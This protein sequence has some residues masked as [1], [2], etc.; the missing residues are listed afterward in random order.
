M[1]IETTSGIPFEIAAGD[2]LNFTVGFSGYPATSYG[3]TFILFNAGAVVATLTGTPSGS[4]FNVTASDEDTANYPPGR[5]TYAAYVTQSGTRVLAERGQISV[6]PNFAIAEVPSEAQTLLTALN[7]ALLS[8]SG[9]ANSSV[10]FNGQ[11]YTKQNIG[12]LMKM[13]TQLRAQVQAEQRAKG[14]DKSAGLKRIVTRFT[15]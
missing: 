13:R 14:Y 11:S 7:A 12:D 8:L 6:T 1:P 4:D 5:Y 10:S 2:T 15:S 3:L 9:S